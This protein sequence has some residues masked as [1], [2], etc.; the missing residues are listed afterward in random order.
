[1]A[2]NI[3][4]TRIAD[5]GEASSFSGQG[6]MS[7]GMQGQGMMT[8][9]MGQGNQDYMTMNVHSNPYGI[10]PPM[11]EGLPH[12]IARPP[13]QNQSQQYP[14]PPSLPSQPNS[15]QMPPEQIALQQQQMLPSRDIPQ[16]MTHHVQDVQIRPNYIP[17]P[18]RAD[19]F[20]K[21]YESK[22][23]HKLK[24]YEKE[25]KQESHTDR[26]FDKFRSPVIAAILFFILHMPIVNTALFKPFSFMSIYNDDGNFNFYGL[27]LKSGVFGAIYWFIEAALDYLGEI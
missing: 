3:K 18:K 11:N 9:G 5:L 22:M 26:A 13:S 6:M 16:D 15:Y 23:E 12:P 1:M 27:I 17:P 24:E 21:E 19:D 8:Q 20:I 10:P 2:E 4:M 14:L 25:K 7:Q